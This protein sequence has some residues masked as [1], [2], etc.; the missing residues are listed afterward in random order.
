M[1]SC[2]SVLAMSDSSNE[3]AVV[4][5]RCEAMRFFARASV[6]AYV[7]KRERYDSDK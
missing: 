5:N 1:C 4:G 3:R 6:D 2:G 7:S